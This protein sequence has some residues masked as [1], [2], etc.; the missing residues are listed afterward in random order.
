M[1]APM[2]WH[3]TVDAYLNTLTAGTARQYGIGLRDFATWYRQHYQEEPEPPL[4]TAE[5]L[6]EWRN[7]LVERQGLQA[8]TVNQRLAA[9]KGLARHVGRRITVTG[10]QRV[11]Q[12]VETLNGRELGRMFAA[13]TGDR[14]L[15]ARNVAL[16]ALM[17]RA[18]L[19][20]AEVCYLNCADV[21]LRPRS[22]SVLI[23]RGKGL[24][25]RSVALSKLARRDVA[26]YQAVRPDCARDRLFITHRGNPLRPRSVERMV[27]RVARRAGIERHVTP[28]TLRHTFAT[29][30]LRRDGDLATLQALL[31]HARLETTARYLHPNLAQVR[32]M[33]EDM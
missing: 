15:D 23:R 28:H 2:N 21:D 17:A 29:R 10:V 3:D 32:Q 7:D 8:A 24:K 11:E 26:A 19:R 33:M 20:V 27:A 6:R 9:V 31:G 30:F 12:P 14:W 16:L 13:A 22:G 4:L 18:G 5:E 1:E 25:E